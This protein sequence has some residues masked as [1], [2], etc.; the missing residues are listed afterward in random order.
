MLFQCAKT[1]GQN[2]KQN[3]T[4]TCTLYKYM[5]IIL[6]LIKS[7]TKE[8]INISSK[9]KSSFWSMSCKKTIPIFSGRI[10]EILGVLNVY[11][12]TQYTNFYL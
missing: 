1:N 5:I 4:N 3:I 9:L 11:I 2:P 6:T 10:K 12:Q 7:D 8:D